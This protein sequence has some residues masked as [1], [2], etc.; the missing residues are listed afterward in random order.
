MTKLFITIDTE[1]EAGFTM[2]RG[3]DSRQ[4]NYRRSIECMTDRGAVGVTYQL[5]VFDRFDLKAVFFVD[6]MPALIWGVAAIEDIVGPIIERGHDV[7]LH[8]HPEWLALAGTNNLLP[9]RTGANMKDFTFDEQCVLIDYAAA[10]LA[11]A[12][13]PAPIAFRAGNYGAND[14]TLRALAAL[15]LAYDSSHCPGIVDSACKISLGPDDRHP[16]EY[17]GVIEV[18]TGC[19]GGP[20]GLRHAQLTALSVSEL[21]AALQHART[22]RI[23]D[24]TLVSHSFELLSRDRTRT[25]RIV[26][27]RFERL[28]EGVSAIDGLT[29]ATYAMM[30]PAISPAAGPRPVLPFNGARTALRIAE[31]AVVNALYGEPRARMGVSINAPADRCAAPG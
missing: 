13:A 5:D 14:D 21:L 19:I 12:G 23:A 7:Q 1:Y 27:R 3:R 25:N 9:G 31:Q 26:K 16:I 18:P 10:T 30:P 11:A 29:T 24:F 4:E 28:C 8:L 15:G 6:P 17:C 22:H 20:G 2:R